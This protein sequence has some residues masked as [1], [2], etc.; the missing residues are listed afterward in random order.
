[1]SDI[2]SMGIGVVV[3]GTMSASYNKT[4][5]G[6]EKR[7]EALAERVGEVNKRLRAAGDVVRYRGELE[8][9][10]RKQAGA[11]G[12]SARLDR[13]VRDLER[14]YRAAKRELKGYGVQVGDAV[15]AQDRL[16][17]ALRD[18]ERAQRGL[19][20]RERGAAGMRRLR[21][22]AATGTGAV[23]AVGRA[24]RS[25]MAHE[26]QR[27]YLGTVINAADG[28][29]E[30]AVGRA[31]RAARAFARESLASEEEVPTIEYAL[32]SAG[33]DEMAARVPR[34]RGDRPRRSAGCRG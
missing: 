27:L 9:L 4:M 6:A 28:D 34:T 25:G 7:Q 29:T 10:R 26:Q 5:L 33:L 16:R 18:T 8:R 13:G 20:L 24:L 3:G 15:R 1:M 2:L 31:V 12:S 17:R 19:A 11:A 30:A 32:N 23:Y 22:A 21:G 14:R